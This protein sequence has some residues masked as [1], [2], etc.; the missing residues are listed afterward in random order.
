MPPCVLIV[1]SYVQDHAWQVD[2]FPVPGETRRA[3]GFSSGPGGKGFNQAIACVRQGVDTVFIGAIGQDALGECARNFASNEGLQSF[4][5]IRND[6][7]TAASSIVVNAAGENMIAVNLA[8]NEFLDESFLQTLT[9]QFANANTVLCQ[10]ENNLDAIHFAFRLAKKNQALCVLNPAPVHPE[11][12]RELLD[13]A[14]V[15]T[16]NETEF[17]LLC[18]RFAGAT[19]TAE[20]VAQ[21][22]HREL[23]DFCRKLSS[24]TIVITLGRFGCFVSHG[25]NLR[26]DSASFYRVAPESVKAIDTTG[27]GDAF[28][29]A[30]VAALSLFPEHS[31]SY[32]IQYAGRVAAMSTETIGTAPAMPNRAQ[33]AARFS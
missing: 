31:F 29:G 1:G 32:A 11:L 8:A 21:I 2:N 28:S 25:E 20:Q 14:D 27:A 22:D 24:N 6:M 19:F 16:P 10:L 4:W 13:L 9:V 3:L 15:L 17:A 5:Q 26:N 12:N 33:V 7:P 18:Q 30:L 23:H